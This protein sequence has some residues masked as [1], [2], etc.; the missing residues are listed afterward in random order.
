M[1]SSPSGRLVSFCLALLV[2]ALLLSLSVRP[3][4]ADIGAYILV[5][6]RTGTVLEQKNATGKWYPASLTKMMTAYVTF[7][8]IREGRA[9]L[10]SAVVQSKNS[11][12]E[13]PSKMG[14]KVGTRFTVDTALKIILIKSANDVAVALG[15]AIGGSEANFIAM[16]NAEARRLGMTNTRF[17][18]PHGLPD[19]AQ[20]TTA[21]DLAILAMALRNDFPESRDYYKHPGI[22][23]G[24]K[25]LR[26]ANR[27]FL[28]RV[29]GANGMKTGYICNSGYNV[30][31]TVTRRGRTLLAIV[32]GA[33]SGL[34]RTAFARQL[35][36]EGF[37]KNRGGQKVTSLS[38]PSSPPPA[39]GYC[40]RNKS[41]G[42]KG[43]MARFDMENKTRGGFLFFA[44]AGGKKEAEVD[45]SGFMLANGKPD[46]A[47]ILDRTLGPRQVA[48]RPIQVSLGKPTGTPAASASTSS[49]P[50]DLTVEDIP[51]PAANPMRRAE[52]EMR[53]K[54][55]KTAAAAAI[56][57]GT[58][59]VRPGSATD[60]TKAAP[61]SIFR[62]GLGFSVPVPAPSPRKP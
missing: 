26:S 4:Q 15:E 47:K 6:A 2:P 44:D 50:L 45:E 40:R 38:G 20:V 35:F 7:K 23:F 32:L 36:D 31:A 48:Y 21:R 17:T 55:Q 25:T 27:E 18:N 61:G 57:E 60:L 24:K 30:A 28:L 51:L 54:L 62:Q 29:P 49:A 8:A 56:T 34:E 12:S 16:M 14:F 42:P 1:F 59:S 19:N 58:E 53:S 33:G 43:Y 3:A 10:N 39:D 37:R 52:I 22:R 41:P 46:W 11:L 13:P 9:S 5:D